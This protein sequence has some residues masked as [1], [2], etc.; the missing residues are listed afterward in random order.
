[1][2]VHFILII[3]FKKTSIM[4]LLTTL[5]TLFWEIPDARF[6]FM[7]ADVVL[8]VSLYFLRRG[9]AAEEKLRQHELHHQDVEH[10]EQKEA[11]VALKQKTHVQRAE[12]RRR[13]NHGV[14]QKGGNNNN[15]TKAQHHIQQPSSKTH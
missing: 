5:N 1:L 6:P 7:V 11:K 10:L 2:I 8:L 3:Y 9:L 13:A 12:Q 14:T 15:K 4:V